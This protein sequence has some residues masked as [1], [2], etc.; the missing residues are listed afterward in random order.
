MQ[1]DAIPINAQKIGENL[2]LI[3]LFLVKS[4]IRDLDELF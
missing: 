3:S 2:A 4:T 1:A